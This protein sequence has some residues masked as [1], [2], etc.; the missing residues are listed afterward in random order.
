MSMDDYRFTDVLYEN[1]LA[2]QSDVDGFVL[3]GD[4][5]VSFPQDRRAGATARF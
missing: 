4:A 3:E 1:P 5:A 2:S